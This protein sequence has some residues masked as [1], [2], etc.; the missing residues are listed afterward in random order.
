MQIDKECCLS[1]ACT[2]SDA[3][4]GMKIY[5]SLKI[6]HRSKHR[7]TYYL[8]YWTKFSK[9]DIFKVPLWSLGRF[10]KLKRVWLFWQFLANIFH[11]PVRLGY[12]KSLRMMKRKREKGTEIR[13]SEMISW[14]LL[15]FCSTDHKSTMIASNNQISDF[16]SKV[17]EGILSAT[18]IQKQPQI[19]INHR[20]NNF[21]FID[22]KQTQIVANFQKI[23]S[24]HSWNLW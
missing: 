15:P 8:T 16:R 22:K 20:L 19:S 13:K 21:L 6:R 14:C 9:D 12:E 24:C 7:T 4:W 3:C 10:S 5:I 18:C 11:K 23:W 2:K 17:L 1:S